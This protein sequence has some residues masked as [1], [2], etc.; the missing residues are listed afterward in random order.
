M[1]VLAKL[2]P[3]R[4]WHTFDEESILGSSVRFRDTLIYL[5]LLGG[6]SRDS[7]WFLL[8]FQ[9][10]LRPWFWSE[11]TYLVPAV[12]PVKVTLRNHPNERSRFIEQPW[13]SVLC[14]IL[15]VNTT[16]LDIL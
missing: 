3:N 7:C 11:K 1:T 12:D 16:A 4:L 6:V 14:V 13:G 9:M 10:I 2:A 5:E 8:Q 15:S